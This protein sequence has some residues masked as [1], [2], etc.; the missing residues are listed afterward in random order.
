[1]H[2]TQRPPWQ[3]VA[4]WLAVTVLPQSALAYTI[5]TEATQGCHE[6]ITLGSWRHVGNALPEMAAPLP[7]SGDDEAL[8]ADVPFS[9]PK[10]MQSIGPVTLLLGVRDNDVKEHGPTDLKNLTPA[11][12]QPG[13]QAEH[14]LR[15]ADDD[16]PN[17]SRDAVEAC[18]GFIRESLLRSLDGLDAA[19]KP[20]PAKRERLRVA[21]AIRDEIDVDVPLFFLRAGRAIHAL[22]DSFTHTFRSPDEPGKIRVVLNFVEYTQ[23]TLD[24]AVDGPPHASELDVC[25]DPDE[26]RRARRA[27]AA[28][29]GGVA[30]LA[31]LDPALDRPAKE[32]AIDAM[33]DS[34]VSFDTSVACSLDNGW[35]DAPERQYGSPPL[36]CQCRMGRINP[37]GG[38][39]IALG[40][41]LGAGLVLRRRRRGA[42]LLASAALSCAAAEARAEESSGPIAGPTSA[43]AGK[44]D[45]AT[46]GKVDQG[47][48]FLARVAAGASYD[49]AAFST[50][51][52]LRYHLSEKWMV[53]FDAEWNPYVAITPGK[54]RSGSANAYVSLIRR[55]QLRRE[56]I[57]VR[58]T[59]SLG[60][61]MLLFDLVG[62]DQYS[63]GPFFGIGFLG[64]EWKMARGFY[65]TIDPT[66][67]AIPVPS[68]VGVP[69]M[70]AQYR[71]LVGLEFGG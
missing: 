62:A 69:F 8:I 28:E 37:A 33:L 35:C 23:D 45:V 4:V 31:V 32:H 21:L 48:A 58:S 55:F 3:L 39:P 44:S 2:K 19:G 14:C 34:Y 59:A 40:L 63:L 70:Y 26:L 49:N 66:Y 67:V 9:V 12:S 61:S 16:E 7:S 60:A 11:A 27:L 46:P 42:G 36:G 18:R 15:A 10:S 29:A 53:G 51:L 1:M 54:V 24:E 68:I 6:E 57:N 71:F 65:L 47:G 5:E 25:D 56:S 38:G 22:Q 50:G 17:G 30:L 52:G 64:V 43:L 41:L 20:D 13:A